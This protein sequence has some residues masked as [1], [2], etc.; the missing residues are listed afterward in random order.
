MEDKNILE[1]V[2]DLDSSISNNDYCEEYPYDTRN[3]NNELSKEL[4]NN[5]H[6]ALLSLVN[7]IS[8]F[9]GLIGIIVSFVV[10]KK[11]F[12]ES[13]EFRE[14]LRNLLNFHLSFYI[15]T[16][17]ITLISKI[18]FSIGL[19]SFSQSLF[20]GIYIT[21]IVGLLNAIKIILFVVY[22]IIFV[23]VQISLDKDKSIKKQF[24]SIN[25]IKN[26]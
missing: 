11:T 21:A 19:L 14:N 2:N 5:N 20:L 13:A 24:L 8:L 7:F 22:I 23:I 18:I 6:I 16:L 10:N 12:K 15:Y 25:L 17:A 3:Y 1:E 9:L 26:M 4:L